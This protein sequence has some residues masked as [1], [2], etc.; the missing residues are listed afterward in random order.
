VVTQGI[1]YTDFDQTW[2]NMVIGIL[3]L[4]AVL[5]NNTFRQLALSAAT[6]KKGA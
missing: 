1:Y 3:L 6:R 5:M 4:G 2:S